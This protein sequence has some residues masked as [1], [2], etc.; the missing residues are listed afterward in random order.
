MSNEPN[1]KYGKD[2]IK[3]RTNELY[4]LLPTDKEER[5][6]RYDIR[7]EVIELNYAFFGYV[8]LNTEL[9]YPLQYFS[10]RGCPRKS[11]GI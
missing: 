1:K 6:K 3:R 4:D 10:N 7:D 2:Y 11:D 8:H 5:K 9:I